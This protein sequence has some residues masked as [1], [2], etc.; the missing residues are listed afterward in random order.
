MSEEYMKSVTVGE[1]VED[2]EVQEWAREEG[3][4]GRTAEWVANM[5]GDGYGLE[6]IKQL[7]YLE[8]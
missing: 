5:L 6:D 1:L 4:F 2:M 3:I 7:Y 8:A